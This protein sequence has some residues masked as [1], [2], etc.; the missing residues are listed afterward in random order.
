MPYRD[1][2]GVTGDRDC[3][4]KADWVSVDFALPKKVGWYDILTLHGESEAPF[5]NNAKGELVWLLP[6]PLIITHWKNK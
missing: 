5:V 4:S 6:D 2:F 3:A 1:T